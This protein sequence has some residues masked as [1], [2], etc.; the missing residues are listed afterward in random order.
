LEATDSKIREEL[1]LVREHLREDA[2]HKDTKAHA[3]AYHRLSQLLTVLLRK[4]PNSPPQFAL[5]ESP[6]KTAETVRR[7]LVGDSPI[8][9]I[10]RAGT[11][12]MGCPRCEEWIDITK[13][14][15]E[16]V[17]DGVYLCANQHRVVFG[18]LD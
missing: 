17:F 13:I 5:F 8:P 6:Q 11:I 10:N 7:S 4:L 16:G 3:R 18:G 2:T 14:F 9:L 15:T 12:F 1:A